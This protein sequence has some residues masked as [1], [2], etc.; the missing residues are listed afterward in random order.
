MTNPRVGIVGGGLAGLATAAALCERGFPVEI[1]ESRRRLGGRAGSFQDPETNQQLDHCQHVG[2]GCCTNFSDLCRRTG[3]DRYFRTDRVLHFIGPNGR[4][5]NVTSAWWLPAPGH[6]LPSVLRL[7]FLTWR[8]RLKCCIALWQLAR[9]RGDGVF[10]EPTIGQWLRDLGQSQQA[11]DRFWSVILVSALSESVDRASLSAARKVFVDGFMASRRA[12]VVNVPT[13][14]LG[15]LYDDHLAH[16]LTSKGVKIHLGKSA[17]ELTSD[18]TNVRGLRL[19]DGMVHN[20]DYV[21]LAV[22][23]RRVGKILPEHLAA[24]L[25]ELSQVEEIES[26]PI[27]AVHLRF[28]RSITTLPH[29]VMIDRFAQWIFRRQR[30]PLS[31]D[32]SQ[33]ADD[34]QVVISASRELGGNG[35]DKIIRQIREDINSAWPEAS[36]ARLLHAR[37]VTQRDAVFSAR[38]E[39]EQMRPGQRTNISNLM[40]AGDWTRTGWPSTMEGAVRSGYLAAEEILQAEGGEEIVLQPDLRRSWLTQ[41]LLGRT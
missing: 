32:G 16:W 25:Q 20:F 19:D 8:E 2:M 30:F 29:A 39:T 18:G 21:V 22:P 31:Q 36:T 6:L 4:Q 1:F 26:V 13:L 10:P 9:W 27:T 33:Q 23:W 38:P 15:E 24:S 17:V 14:P 11:I 40:L 34:Y 41:L 5:Y 37:V 28:D 12:Y 7:G 35:R 3:I